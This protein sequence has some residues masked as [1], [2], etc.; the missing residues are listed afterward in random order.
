MNEKRSFVHQAQRAH[1][2]VKF[3]ILGKTITDFM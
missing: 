3:L 1:V 2:G